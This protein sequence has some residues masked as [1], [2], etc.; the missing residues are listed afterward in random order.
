MIRRQFLKLAA[1]TG[2]TGLASIGTL[3]AIEKKVGAATRL[4]VETVDWHVAGFTC[5]TCAVGLETM[6]RQQKGVMSV[7][8]SYPMAHVTI[9]FHPD[10]VTEA[11]LRSYISDLG[12]TASSGN[13]PTQAQ[14]G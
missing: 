10:V 7:V 3:D 2:V 5:V 13:A 6:L 4:P 8:A 12:F 1:L 11:T 14:R 9:Q